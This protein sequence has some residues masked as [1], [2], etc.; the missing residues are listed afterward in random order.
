M[1]ATLHTTLCREATPSLRLN[2]LSRQFSRQSVASLPLHSGIPTIIP[3]KCRERCL[4]LASI[5]EPR[6]GSRHHV[7]IPRKRSLGPDF[8]FKRKP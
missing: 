4:Q 3:T 8:L 2:W 1:S 6:H 7:V 5:R